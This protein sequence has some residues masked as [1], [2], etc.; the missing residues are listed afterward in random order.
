MSQMKHTAILSGDVLRDVA[1]GQQFKLN[2]TQEDLQRGVWE[3]HPY[4]Q[5]RCYI[6]SKWLLSGLGGGYGG[7]VPSGD[8][9]MA[10]WQQVV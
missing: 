3:Y 2:P 10:I 6:C 5:R 7:M 9:P 4:N 1:T 8:G